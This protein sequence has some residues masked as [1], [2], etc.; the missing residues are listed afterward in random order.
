MEMF[1]STS[2]APGLFFGGSANDI[3]A[4]GGNL[5][6]IGTGTENAFHNI[7]S[8]FNGASSVGYV[9]GVS[10]G[11]IDTGTTGFST[12]SLNMYGV[13]TGGGIE[14]V[15]NIYFTAN[16]GSSLAALCT[17]EFSY[18]GTSVSC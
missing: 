6:S 15:E 10:S 11:T 18:W 7:A 3:V 12:N 13:F 9:D 2:G 5:P 8:T 14:T 17:N 1:G 4:F 16:K